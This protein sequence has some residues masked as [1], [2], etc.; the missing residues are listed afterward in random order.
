M[1]WP[2]YLRWTINL[3]LGVTA[4][5]VYFLTKSQQRQPHKTTA[6]NQLHELRDDEQILNS[7]TANLLGILIWPV[8]FDLTIGYQ[9]L[10]Q[11]PFV[12]IGFLWPLILGIVNLKNVTANVNGTDFPQIDASLIISIS[13]A[14]GTLLNTT[15]ITSSVGTTMLLYSLLLSIGFV[16]PT[17]FLERSSETMR[18]F[19]SFQRIFLNYSIGYVICA[20]ILFIMGK[21]VKK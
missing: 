17:A 21:S 12:I 20:I 13:F 6:N 10:F 18:K 5:V 15:S 14:L 8:F 4:I 11:H 19:Q 1:Q 16:V 2:S 7:T 9:V 3:V